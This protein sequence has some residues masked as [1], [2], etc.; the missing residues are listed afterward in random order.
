MQAL[1]AADHPTTRRTYPSCR[2]LLHIPRS[3][4][5]ETKGNDKKA[6]PSKPDADESS[7]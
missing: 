4:A 7:N 3:C 5:R 1:S 6:H 2:R